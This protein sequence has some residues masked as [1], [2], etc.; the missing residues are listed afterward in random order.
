MIAAGL[1]IELLGEHDH[2]AYHVGR[3]WCA[4]GSSTGCPRASRA[5][6]VHAAGAEAGSP[7][8]RRVPEGDT[9]HSAARARIGEL[10]G[11]EIEEIETPQSRHALDRWPERLGGRAVREVDAR[12][13]FIRFEVT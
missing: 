5:C 8:L 6:H 11:R 1:A 4:T 10:V 7:S 9:I 12:V 2:Q 3:S 13:L